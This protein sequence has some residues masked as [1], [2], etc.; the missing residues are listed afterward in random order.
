MVALLG[1]RR[2]F[3]VLTLAPPVRRDRYHVVLAANATRGAAPL[4]FRRNGLRVTL[5]QLVRLT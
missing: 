1:L 5:S 3:V 4:A 2:R